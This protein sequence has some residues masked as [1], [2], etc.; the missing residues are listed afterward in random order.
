MAIGCTHGE[1]LDR[2][3]FD[4]V[5]AFS[6]RWKPETKVHLGDVNDYAAFRAGA[7]G[8]SD[9]AQQLG[10]DILAGVR[11]IEEYAPTHLLLGNHD[12]RAWKLSQSPNAIVARAAQSARNEFLTAVERG[13]VHLIDHYDIN[14]SWLQL[15]DTK[16]V[17]GYMYGENAIRDHAEH[18]GK[19]VLAQLHTPGIARGRRCDHPA[20]YCVG[21]LANIGAMEYANTRR[22][23]AR[24]AHGFVYGEYNDKECHVWLSEGEPNQAGS[25]RLPL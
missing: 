2:A 24:W 14:R 12:I 16:F 5:L 21:T 18:F 10:P 15:G 20:A 1:L 13:G 25:W 22:A 6:A 7:R 3:A 19:C 4:T 9:E 23:T 11:M 17:H 8:T